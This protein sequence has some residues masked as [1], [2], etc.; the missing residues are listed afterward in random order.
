MEI[1]EIFK[2]I[3]DPRSSR[4]KQYSLQA[5]MLMSI[6]AM[7]AGE[8]SFT[9]I[10]DYAENNYEELSKYVDLPGSTPDHETFRVFLTV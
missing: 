1:A 8:T 6:C 5:L 3:T 2:G 7:M 9:G 4:K 10:A